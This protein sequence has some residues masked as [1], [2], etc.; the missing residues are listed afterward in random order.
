MVDYFCGI[1]AT[2]ASVCSTWQVS[3]SCSLHDS[4]VSATDDDFSPLV[5]LFKHLP[6][7]KLVSTKDASEMASIRFPRVLWFRC[8][9]TSLDAVKKNVFRTE[10]GGQFLENLYTGVWQNHINNILELVIYSEDTESWNTK[11]TG[12]AQSLSCF[13]LS[14]IS[15]LLPYF[16]YKLPK[17][18][19]HIAN[20]QFS[21]IF[22]YN[23][24]LVLCLLVINFVIF[25]FGCYIY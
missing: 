4:Q 12:F 9:V 18:P 17:E 20:S 3:H 15:Y 6:A 1:Q 24:I 7:P 8:V 23:L 10:M 21:W 5:A 2:V 22:K 14:L 19:K 25:F 11:S 16:M 13:T